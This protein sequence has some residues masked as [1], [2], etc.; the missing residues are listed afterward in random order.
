MNLFTKPITSITFEDI[1]NFC[2]EGVP[3][4]LTVEYK[5][6]FPADNEK[7]AKVISSFANTQGGIVLIGVEEKDGKPISVKCIDYFEGIHEKI[8]SICLKNIY[9]PI[10]PEIH[11]CPSPQDEN[12]VVVIIRVAESDETLH[13]VE[14]GT[15]IYIRVARQIEPVEAPFEEI[16]WLRN[17]RQE[18]LR[19]RRREAVQNRIRL[20]IRANQRFKEQPLIKELGSFRNIYLIPLYPSRILVDIDNFEE[21]INKS[22]LKLRSVGFEEFPWSSYRTLNESIIFERVQEVQGEAILNHL[23]INQ[24]GLIWYKEN[25]WEDLIERTRGKIDMFTVLKW[26]FVIPLFSLNFY[27]NVGCWGA[28][29]INLT[30]EGIRGRPLVIAHNRYINIGQGGASLDDC[31]EII[32]KTSVIDLKEKLEGIVL[33][34]Y[35]EFLWSCGLPR[36]AKNQETLQKHLNTIKQDFGIRL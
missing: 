22:K 28:I 14:Q 6:E 36:I 33:E 32:R 5:R 23:E 26:L 18:W 10:F 25:L 17:R 16:E 2:R 31:I 4:G 24:Y 20:I 8:T 21:M 27:K 12:K 9:P 29:E 34:L 15:K 30:L 7:L 35:K 19:N 11:V 1:E 3:E 13:W